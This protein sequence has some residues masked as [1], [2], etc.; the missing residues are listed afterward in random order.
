MQATW[1]N[2]VALHRLALGVALTL[3][4]LSILSTCADCGARTNGGGLETS[5]GLMCE[6]CAGDYAVCAHCESVTNDGQET[7]LSTDTSRTVYAYLCASCSWD[8]VEA[9]AH[10]CGTHIANYGRAQRTVDAYLRN[11]GVLTGYRSLSDHYCGECGTICGECYEELH[12]CENCDESYCDSDSHYDCGR[13]GDLDLHGYSYKPMPLFHGRDVDA[14]APTFGMELETAY[15]TQEH[16]D[17]MS[18]L[19]N[20]RAWYAKEDS[21]CAGAEF[22]SHPRTYASWVAHLADLEPVLRRMVADGANNGEI[23]SNGI[24]VHVGR[25]AFTGRAHL[26]RFAL[27]IDSGQEWITKLARRN[28]REWSEFGTI[29]RMREFYSQR[30]YG[31]FNLYTLTDPYGGQGARGAVNLQNGSTVEVRVWRQ[32]LETEHVIGAIGFVAAAVEYTRNLTVQ[33]VMAGALTAEGFIDY[34]AHKTEYAPVLA[35][36]VSILPTYEPTAWYA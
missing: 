15:V 8:A 22:V 28:S 31:R 36:L 30:S 33:E 24:H 2:R 5:N 3:T 27:L 4:E 35:D 20:G 32:S 21:T 9:C 13:S 12:Y 7:A 1:I 14:K 18:A 23:E 29:K 34:L 19:D 10:G 26:A 6:N 16:V 25:D 11:L 17:A